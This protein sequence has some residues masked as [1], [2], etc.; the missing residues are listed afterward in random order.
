MGIGAWGVEPWGVEAL[1][2][3]NWPLL[4]E[5]F[6]RL[7]SSAD[8]SGGNDDRGHFL[9]M[10]GPDA[11]LAEAQGP[12]CIVRIWSANPSGRLLIFLDDLQQPKVDC[13]FPALFQG[14]HPPF[15]PPFVGHLSG[16]WVC[17]VPLPFQERCKV[18]LR[19]PSRLYYQIAVQQL[20]P[21]TPVEPFE[22]RQLQK[23]L[24]HWAPLWEGHRM[25]EGGEV[26]TLRRPVPPGGSIDLF[27]ALQ[28]GILREGTLR[29]QPNALPVLERLRLQAF[30]DGAP[31]PSL[32]V[33]LA[34]FFGGGWGLA[35][36]ASLPL[37]AGPQGLTWRLPMPF[38]QARIRLLNESPSRIFVEARLRWEPRA[39]GLQRFGRLHALFRAG[40]TQIG[41]PILLL[42]T[43]SRGHLAGL[44]LSLRGQED[45]RYLEGDE[46]IWVDDEERPSWQGTGLEDL[47]N[48]AWYFLEGEVSWALSGVVRLWP[49]K[50]ALTA[51]RWFLPD[52]I[53][54]RRRIRFL[55][56]HGAQND[57]PGTQY[58]A[59]VFWYQSEARSVPSPQPPFP[60]P[61]PLREEGGQEAEAAFPQAPSL[62]EAS[63]PAPLSGG[64]GVEIS[65]APGSFVD[66][67]FQ[68]AEERVYTPLLRWLSDRGEGTVRLEL[69]G[70]LLA[71]PLAWAQGMRWL[72]ILPLPKQ[73]LRAGEHTLRLGNEGALPTRVG[74]D[75][76]AL[77]PAQRLKGALEAEEL[78]RRRGQGEVEDLTLPWSGDSAF[79]WQPKGGG[80]QVEWLVSVAMEGR[81]GVLGRFGVGPRMGQ[82]EV[83]WDGKPLGPPID[84]RG[85]QE[86]PSEWLGLGV[87]PWTKEGEHILALR[88]LGPLEAERRVVVDCFALKPALGGMEA[89][90]LPVLEASA[91]VEVRQRFGAEPNWF[92]GAYLRLA[93]TQVGHRLRLLVPLEG[94][95][96]H[97][98]RVHYAASNLAGRF[99]LR[100]G[101]RSLGPVDAGSPMEERREA[102]LGVLWLWPGRRSLEVEVLGPGEGS[103]GYEV[104][105][106]RLDFE[107]LPWPSWMPW[108]AGVFLALLLAGLLRRFLLRR[109][110]G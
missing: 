74:L 76:I 27:R 78:P 103:G 63:S 105:L 33:P 34:D 81:Y 49:R 1:R 44:V 98:L 55:L 90:C 68:V 48:A 41:E 58:R 46:T 20:P 87:T 31:Q 104:G 50:E 8:P 7:F 25:E 102:D 92:G 75:A 65:L 66:W 35:Q 9:R 52:A 54:F 30:W 80:D 67:N 70:R 100:L 21:G 53:P 36:W 62:A 47:F 97:R 51:Y 28:P 6:C 84:L 14:R 77:K 32:D 88:W 5:G 56:E 107:P 79:A 4:R 26:V 11:V 95:G 89:E 83:L 23:A 85:P 2:L 16:G 57:A 39:E 71:T 15:L 3:E 40:A 73:R 99:L 38:S 59:V 17:M 18:V 61:P 109:A 108:T 22:P 10:E 101:S 45:L 60:S 96:R 42:E 106:D 43:Q 110:L 64:R 12:G 19:H 91:P 37:E 86:A 69:D 13:D 24:D 29:V 94:W 82:V 93:S 72:H